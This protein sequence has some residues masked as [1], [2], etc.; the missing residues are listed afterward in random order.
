MEKGEGFIEITGYRLT[1]KICTSLKSKFNCL[2][3]CL[4]FL[5]KWVEKGR[6]LEFINGSLNSTTLYRFLQTGNLYIVQIELLTRAEDKSI[7]NVS[8]FIWKTKTFSLCAF[9][10]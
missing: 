6:A 5:E 8:L 10:L 9:F 4:V 3:K 2:L 7:N 1:L